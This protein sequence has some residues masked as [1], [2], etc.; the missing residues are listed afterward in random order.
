MFISEKMKSTSL[1]E[2]SNRAD[3]KPSR[4]LLEIHPSPFCERTIITRLDESSLPYIGQSIRRL[5]FCTSIRLPT[6][7]LTQLLRWP[8]SPGAKN[9]V[10]HQSEIEFQLVIF[11]FLCCRTLLIDGFSI[12]RQNFIPTSSKCIREVMWPDFSVDVGGVLLPLF[13]ISLHSFLSFVCRFRSLLPPNCCSRLFVDH[14]CS[15]NIP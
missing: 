1:V 6:R 3:Q 7:T 2:H 10:I 9:R 12:I 5:P 13:L 8:F 15:R 11:K 4:C 14:G